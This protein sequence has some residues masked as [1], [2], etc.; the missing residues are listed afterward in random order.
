[1]NMEQWE[2]KSVTVR[3]WTTDDFIKFLNH[4]GFLGWELISY[5]DT[6]VRGLF[7]YS[8]SRK[9]LFKRKKSNDNE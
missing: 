3:I 9:C 1:M 2:Y 7:A 6:E 5:K 8:I 4:E